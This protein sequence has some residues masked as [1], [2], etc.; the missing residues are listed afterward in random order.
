MDKQLLKK[1]GQLFILLAAI[2][3]L[4]FIGSLIFS[5]F[6]GVIKLIIELILGAVVVGLLYIACLAYFKNK[7]R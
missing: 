6:V 4:I 7:N 3:I 5:L 1:I 2:C